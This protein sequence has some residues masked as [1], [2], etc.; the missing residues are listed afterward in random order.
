M[1]IAVAHWSNRQAGGTGTYLRTVLPGLARHH[2]LAFVHELDAPTDAAPL[3]LPEGAPIWCVGAS[4]LDPVLAALRRWRPDVLFVN[5]LRDPGHEAALLDVA[6]AV[7]LAHDYHG[8]CISGRKA[9]DVPTT[10]PCDRPFGPSCLVQYLPRRCGGRSPVTMLREYRRQ[11]ARFALLRRYRRIVTLSSHLARE[12]ARYGLPASCAWQ[13]RAAGPAAGMPDAGPEPAPPAPGEPWHLLFAGRT[14]AIK[15]GRELL[16][17]LPAVAARLGRPVSLTIA[18]DGADRPAW[19][20]CAREVGARDPRVS[21]RFEGWVGPDAMA[22]LFS[23]SHLLVVPS[24]WPEPLGLVGLEAGRHGVPAAGYA[25]GGI[26]DWLKPGV[27][28]AL[29]PGDPPTVGGLADAIIAC[30]AD[31]ATYVRLSAGARRLSA[32]NPFGGHLEALLGIFDD[33]VRG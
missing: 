5:G 27:N 16:L 26:P 9:F 1:R 31:P 19:E 8:T 14:F 6:P 20:S 12:Y 32:D 30:L 17:A 23:G 29:A 11:A 28:G 7:M 24:L 2:A 25:V 4:G 18:G 3:A 10:R 15:G 21:V 13:V 33:V 22:R